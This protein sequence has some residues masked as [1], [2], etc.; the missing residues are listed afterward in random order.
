MTE[1]SGDYQLVHKCTGQWLWATATGDGV[2]RC[3]LVQLGMGPIAAT[4]IAELGHH[5]SL[6]LAQRMFVFYTKGNCL[7]RL[8]EMAHMVAVAEE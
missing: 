4:G 5:F 6:L 7:K 3:S 2:T 1:S 8:S